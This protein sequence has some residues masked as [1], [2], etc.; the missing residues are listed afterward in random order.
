MDYQHENDYHERP[1][2]RKAITILVILII[3]GV[4]AGLYFLLE[5]LGPML[6]WAGVS[7]GALG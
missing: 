1:S 3:A 6:F 2:R 4:V 5:W 7:G